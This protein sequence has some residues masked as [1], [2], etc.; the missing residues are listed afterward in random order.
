MKYE[1]LK[2]KKWFNAMLVTCVGIILYVAL[3]NISAVLGTLKTL[4]GYFMPLII[5]CVLAYLINPLAKFFER[6][7]V[8]KISNEKVRW[9]VSSVVAIVLVVLILG[10]LLGTLIPQLVD[11]IKTFAGNF[12]DYLFSLKEFLDKWQIS[13]YVDV[14]K[15]LYSSENISKHVITYITD[16][17][18]NIVDASAGV[19]KSLI[20]WVLGFILSVY[21]IM[22][23]KS[24]VHGV[25]RFLRALFSREKYMSIKVFLTRCDDILSH[26]IIYSIIECVLI[27]VVTAIFMAIMGMQYVGLISVVVAVTNL[28][29]TFGP[30]IGGVLGAF[31]LILV[32]PWHSLAFIIF[33]LILQTIDG[34]VIKPKL[35]GNSLGVSGLLILIT[36]IVGGKMFGVIGILL[37]IPFAA[38]IDFIY[39]D[40]ILASLEKKRLLTYSDKKDKTTEPIEEK[41]EISHE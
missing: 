21:L 23:K 14:Q 17:I 29:P 27:G 28:I 35:F 4:F 18:G 11:S 15:V 20:N 12:D 10:F 33:A 34:Y 26:Y 5:G 6:K 16:N 41:Q 36:I 13:K 40:Y 32:N 7:V 9:S 39:R 38:I 8:C 24:L 31:I 22:A 1:D 25:G 3:S 37:S 2:E 30:V 19:G